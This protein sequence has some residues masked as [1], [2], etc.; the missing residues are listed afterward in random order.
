MITNEVNGDV[1]FYPKMNSYGISVTC[2]TL[3]MSS[4][5]AAPA[6]FEMVRRQGMRDSS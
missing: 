1:S 6:F 3:H 5:L 4:L 2:V